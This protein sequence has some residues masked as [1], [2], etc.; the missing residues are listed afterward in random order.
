MIARLTRRSR[1]IGGIIT[2]GL[3]L[4][5]GLAGRQH[6]HPPITSDAA[7]EIQ[8]NPP[9][10]STQGPLRRSRENP[11]YFEDANGRLVYLTGAHTWASVQDGGTPSHVEQFDYERFL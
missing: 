10:A 7:L 8:L 5:A 1:R 9:E 6:S 2:A 4:V 11:R 3:V